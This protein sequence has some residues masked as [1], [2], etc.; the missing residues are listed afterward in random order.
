MPNAKD[1]T[2]GLHRI[3]LLGNTGTGKTSQF[4]TLP[5]KKF[6]YIFDP[7]A[8]QTLRGY[9]VEF[10]EFLPSAVKLDAVPSSKEG[11]AKADKVMMTQKADS[12]LRWE[13]DWDDKYNK[14]YFN[15]FDWI[16]F[17]SCTTFLD[18]IMERLLTIEGRQGQFPQQND[19]GPQMV[20]F[21]NIV[22]TA[23]SLN[24]PLFFTGH[25][26]T[27]KDEVT[28]S[29]VQ[30]PLFTGQ[31]RE[32]LPLLFSD[33][34]LTTATADQVH[35]TVKYTIRSTPNGRETPIRT[36]LRGLNSIEDVTIDWKK[37]PVGQGLGGLLA[38][39][40]VR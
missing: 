20:T 18:L 21:T 8:L 4:L 22:R 2:E 10:E 36:S 3:L 32:K 7:N 19:W 24:K 39:H 35:G 31:L 38:K 40:G 17:D 6:M 26:K 34:F 16:G 11:Q 13:K 25:L 29:I 37:D 1:V 9:D 5:G 27:D 23:M 33:I 12:Y 28:Q 14:K 15:Q 30:L